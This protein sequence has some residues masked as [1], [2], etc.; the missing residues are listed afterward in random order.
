MTQVLLLQWLLALPL[1]GLAS[2]QNS[3]TNN[4]SPFELFVLDFVFLCT[5]VNL[6]WT[7][8]NAASPFTLYMARGASPIGNNDSLD[9][10][11]FLAHSLA[12]SESAYIDDTM[13]ELLSTFYPTVH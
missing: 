1:L 11:Q 9:A 3:S 12:T 13:G 5:S 2:A 7:D 4:S 6:F 10:E 8:E